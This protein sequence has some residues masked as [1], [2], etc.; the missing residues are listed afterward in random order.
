MLGAE[1]VPVTHRQPDAEGRHATRRCGTGS[2]AVE[3]SHYCIGSVMGPH[4]YPWMVREFQRVIGD[5][6]RAQCAAELPTAVPGLRGRL[7]GRRLQRGRHVRRVRRHRRPAGRGRGRGR[8]RDQPRAASACC[9]AAARMVLQDEDGQVA[10]AH[11]I[12]AG[13]DYPGVGPEHAHLARPRPGPLRD[14]DRRRGG[15]RRSAGSPA[16]R[17]S[18]ARSSRRTRSPGCCGPPADGD[19][20]PP[21]STVLLTLSGRGD[22][23]MADPDG[24]C[25]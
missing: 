16:P 4:P 11:S 18:S 8:R 21:G 14:R 24:A 2:A 20:L 17:A 13:L 25:M 6:A 19:D 5:E 12:A 7:R 3:D 23:D 9:T 10:E 22:K 15:R 1:V